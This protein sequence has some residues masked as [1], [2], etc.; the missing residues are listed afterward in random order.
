VEGIVRVGVVEDDPHSREQ[1]VAHLNR[2]EADRG[3]RFD[4]SVFDD[5]AGLVTGYRPEYDVLLLD[6]EMERVSGMAAARRVRELD[7]DVVIVFIT[8]SPRYAVGGYEVQA[9]SY[10]LKPVAYPAFAQE[11]DRVLAQLARRERRTLL[12]QADGA[13]HRV[14]LADIVYLETAGHRVLI[15]THTAT[16]SVVSSLKALEAELDGAA[17]QRCNSGYLVNLAHVT[18]VEQSEC[19]LRDG[20]VLPIS[21]PKR[22]AFLAALAAHIGS[23]GAAS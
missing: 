17:F 21:R 22:K 16:H 20:T 10:L 4:V 9:L 5:G 6:I 1:A 15:H 8:N 23:V 19:R 2:Y 3:V 14:D 11:M 13:H 12:F 7:D 18:G